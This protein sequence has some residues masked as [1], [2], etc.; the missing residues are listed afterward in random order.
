LVKLMNQTSQRQL[1]LPLPR[2][3]FRLKNQLSFMAALGC[4]ITLGTPACAGAQEATSSQTANDENQLPITLQAKRISGEQGVQTTADGEAELSRGGLVIRADRLSYQQLTSQAKAK[5]QVW[6]Q[7]QGNTYTGDELQLNLENKQGFLSEPTYFLSRNQAGGSARRIEFTGSERAKVSGAV[8]SSCWRDEN[9]L[10]LPAADSKVQRPAWWLSADKVELD[11]AQNEGRAEGAVLRFLGVPIL[12]A[13][14]LSFPLT[15]ARKSGW[16]PPNLDFDS[17]NGLQWA[18]PYYWNLAPNRDA[19]FTPVINTKRGVGLESEFRYLG[20]SYQGQ[21]NADAVPNDRIAERSRYALSFTHA[22]GLPLKTLLQL[23][24]NRASDDN[25]WKDFGRLRGSLMPRLLSS[26]IHAIR[27]LELGDGDSAVYARV[28]RWQVLQDPAALINAPY[29]RLPQIGLRHV[30]RTAGG[31]QA[32]VQTEWNRFALPANGRITASRPTGSR[33]HTLL[34]LGQRFGDVGWGVTP[35]LA[36]NA[37][38]YRL[39]AAG[40][41]TGT[42]SRAFSRVIPTFSLDSQWTFE[43]PVSFRNRPYLQTLEPRVLYVNTPYR[44]QADVPNFDAAPKDFNFD[45]VFSANQFSGVDRVS[46]THQITAGV[47]SRMLQAQDGAEVLR[48]GAVQRYLIRPQRVT[49]DDSKPF[50]QRFS[51]VILL[52]STRL[53][54]RW[55]LDAA[56]QYSPEISRFTR[57][58]INARYS[59]GPYRTLNVSYRMTRDL[60]EQLGLGGQW[61]LY[62]SSR[63]AAGHGHGHTNSCRGDWYGVGHVNYSQRDR[64][65]VDALGGVEFDAGCWIAR[66][67]VQHQSTGLSESTTRLLLQLELVGL[68]RLGINPLQRLK[69]NIPGYR[70]LREAA[71]DSLTAP[72]QRPSPTPTL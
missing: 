11:F 32:S 52:G 1:A 26:Q 19:T 36:L 13:P 67:V 62:P 31:W 49:P 30:Q 37:A 42:L 56:L 40:T 21:I 61:P 51:D 65:L 22:Q 41:Q 8:Y 34:S 50:T 23:E 48:L 24:V 64:R 68:S 53:L 54:P 55:T 10:R 12:G 35:Q 16:L 6:I 70:L 17:K 66:A 33:W 45:S 7:R 43:R 3:A 20:A 29:E 38:H 72:T 28:Q 39:D 69:D 15:D 58:V 14:V 2:H 18:I 4:L 46:D 60:T 71:D 59:P 5:G 44:D 63:P 25:Y 47:V 9:H 57:S 27:R